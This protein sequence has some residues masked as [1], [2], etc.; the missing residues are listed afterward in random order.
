MIS[1]VLVILFAGLAALLLQANMP[2]LQIALNGASATGVIQNLQ[3]CD[4][5]EDQPTVAFLDK[6]GREHFGTSSGCDIY[7]LNDPL[8][9]HYAP[10]H[11]DSGILTDSGIVWVYAFLI[12][13]AL[14]GLTSLICLGYLAVKIKRL[15]GIG[16]LSLTTFIMAFVLVILLA[17]TLLAIHPGTQSKNTYRHYHV[18]ETANAQGGWAVTLKSVQA[19]PEVGSSNACLVLDVVMGNTSSQ[20]QPAAHGSFKLYDI[21]GQELNPCLSDTSSLS[22]DIPPGGMVEGQIGV[23][24]PTNAHLFWLAFTFYTSD[25]AE[26]IW[27]IPGSAA[28]I[29]T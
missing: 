11:P 2:S 21:T 22:G 16:H 12:I 28:S 6:Q 9:I 25:S 17:G 18:G 13:G 8:T 19:M 5:G 29:P 26:T 24:A 15:R 3:G 14:C 7:I 4:N 20:T 23:E 27:D 1:L 10:A